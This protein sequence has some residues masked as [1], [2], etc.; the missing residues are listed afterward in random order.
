[1]DISRILQHYFTWA[2]RINLIFFTT[3]VVG[4]NI[5]SDIDTLNTICNGQIEF[6]INGDS[7]KVTFLHLDEGTSIGDYYQV[8]LLDGI[9]QQ[10]EYINSIEYG[11]GFEAFRFI[12]YCDSCRISR[13]GM[14]YEKN[15]TFYFNG[16]FLEAKRI[17][18]ILKKIIE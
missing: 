12:L 14:Y 2:I 11:M 7:L 15:A 5:Q 4:Q 17:Y 18:L 9:Y 6:S 16:D 3:A 13:N 8:P 1:M 10:L